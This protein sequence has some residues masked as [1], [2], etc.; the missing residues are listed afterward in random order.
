MKVYQ[1]S[2]LFILFFFAAVSARALTAGFTT[3]PSPAAGCAP[4]IVN[5]TNTSTGATSYSWNFGNSTPLSALTNPATSYTV[6][7]TYTV[8]LTAS[9]GSAT[10][11]ATMVVTVYPLPTV[12]FVANDTT[13]C[14]GAPVGF[15]NTSTGGVPGPMT[16]TWGFGD[17]GSATG[18]NPIHPYT[19]PGFYNVF[20]DVANAQ[21]CHQTLTKTAYIQVLS[22]P[23]PFI[24][25]SPSV[26]CAAP[27]STTFTASATGPAP[28]SYWWQFGNG[29]TS[30]S[31]SPPSQSYPAIGTYTVRLRVTD[32]NGCTDSTTSSVSVGGPTAGFVS[33][34]AA[35]LN[36][37]VTFFN[38]STFHT[39]RTWDYGDGSPISTTDTNGIHTYTVPGT[40][41]VI[42]TVTRSGCTS[43]ISHT[44]T[45]E[46]SPAIGITFNPIHPCPAPATQVITGTVLPLSTVLWQ[47]G[48][49]TTGT[50][51]PVTH[52]YTHRGVKFLKMIVTSPLGCVDTLAKTDT[53]YDLVVRMY[54]FPASGCVP[55]TVN[56]TSDVLTFVPD[57]NAS[58]HPYPYG[59]SSYTWNFGDGSP[60]GGGPMTSH[61]YTAVGVYPVTFTIVT[62]NGCTVTRTDTV[63]VGA[64]PVVSVTVSPTHVCYHHPVLFT[65]T[66]ITG[67]VDYLAW[68][69]GDGSGSY[70]PIATVTPHSFVLPGTFTNTVVPYYN[71]CPGT[72]FVITTPILVDSPKAIMYK[73]HLCS[74]KTKVAFYDS[75]IGANSIIWLFGDGDTSTL[76]NPVHTYPPSPGTYTVCLCAYNAASGCHDTDKVVLHFAD[77]H[78]DF[79]GTPLGVCTGDTVK[80]ISSY[81]GTPSYA[82]T[83]YWWFINGAFHNDTSKN[84]VD[85]FYTP[86]LYSITLLTRDPDGCF[87]TVIKPNYVLCAKPVANFSG[88][89]TNVC[90]GAPVIFT[91][92]STD[93]TG[94]TI[95]NYR[96]DFGDGTTPLSTSTSPTSHAYSSVGVYSVSEI[97]TDNIG[98]KDTMVKPSYIHVTKPTASFIMSTTHPCP[99]V[100]VAFTSTSSVGVVSWNWT[101]GDGSTASGPSPSHA[102]TAAGSYSVKLVVI[103]A[104]GCADS[105]IVPS[106]SVLVGKPTAS[107]T[108]SDTFGVCTPLW[109]NFNSTSTGASGYKWRFG[110]GDSSIITT[111]VEPFNSSGVFTVSLEVTNAWGCRDTAYRTVRVFGYAGAFSYD[112]LWGCAPLTVNF[113]AVVSNISSLK[114][115]F[116]DGVVDSSGLTT[117]I[118]HTYSVVGAFVPRLILSDNTGCK[119]TSLG[120]DT[121]KVDAIYPKIS[122]NPNPVCQSGTFHF[123]DSSTSYWSPVNSW[124]WHFD[125][126]TSTLQSPSWFYDV[127]GTYTV[128]LNVSNAWGCTASFNTTHTVFPPPP[129]TASADT[130]VCV[131]DAAT[132]LGSGG[133]SYSWAPP[134]TLSCVNCNPTQATPLVPSTYTVTGTDIHGCTNTDTV[135]VSQRTHTTASSE[136]EAE[137]CRGVPVPVF[138]YGGTKYTWIPAEGI[139]D[140]FSDHPLAG[141]ATT[142]TYSVVV[143][144][145]SCI[146]DTTYLT[147]TVHPLPVIDA[148]KD[149]YLPEGSTAQIEA[150]GSNIK[151]LTWKPAE[152]LD[153]DTC[154]SAKSEIYVTTTFT[155]EATSPEGCKAKDD[156]TIFL[157][158]SNSQIFIPNSFTPNNDG[159][160]DI[161]Y[162]RGKGIKDV[163][164]FRVYNRWGELMHEKLNCNLNDAA[165]G[166]D[167]S[168][169][170]D[171]PRPDVYVYYI[172]AVCNSDEPI[173]LK[174]DVTILR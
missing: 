143:Q 54:K 115:D 121:I 28:L 76:H 108:L 123:I 125:T 127:A 141:P 64:P 5:F 142:T 100:P 72:P 165:A 87:D 169:L 16:C 53:I 113:S 148:G 144:L 30:G 63:R 119:N 114:W 43:T 6:A 79:V 85:T 93:V 173:F 126:V 136:G 159:K 68:T 36:S 140:P 47:F 174:G 146:P 56:F 163:K 81:T 26:M 17:G 132:L 19:T 133:V 131:G 55:L 154:L 152:T 41:T 9:N 35:C 40:Y 83:R 106:S 61:T 31:A 156:V 74:P 1:K 171:S 20:V 73:T 4:L 162:P 124:I 91:D 32:A 117:T 67:P 13:V 60:T 120:I 89:P 66:I 49:G 157:Y 27:G 77:L 112:T 29:N 116:N 51:N 78:P 134:A 145:A 149:Q 110:N 39:S 62:G 109:V 103:D 38:T 104:N 34:P 94:A 25:A 170:G 14:P 58:G 128:S 21:G 15:T 107:F 37:P 130:V 99:G 11:T 82:P 90:A 42:L 57:T 166:W 12:S 161:F 172:E 33:V 23:T 150:T 122:T 147:V 45:I 139:D 7:G 137:V 97:V 70:I 118:S 8:T 24:F 10:A 155:V 111:P 135:R 167:G 151:S 59:V 138:A 98:C 86:G 65:T 71:G 101:F 69:F 50:G 153:C 3:S 129:I 105:M 48:D 22:T 46:P 18:S 164:V 102:Y 158:C 44:I 80:F 2:L 160:N 52:T 92:A 84:M 75:S 88:A 168:Y 95:T 96:W